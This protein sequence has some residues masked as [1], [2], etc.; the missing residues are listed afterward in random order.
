MLVSVCMML[1]ADRMG[2][3]VLLAIAVARS[4]SVGTVPRQ[5]RLG[6]AAVS[7]SLTAY[8]CRRT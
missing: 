8:L 6:P 7:S 3:V 4:S 1:G 2:F 5:V